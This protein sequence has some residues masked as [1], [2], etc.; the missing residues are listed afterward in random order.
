MT[1]K[2]T[3]LSDIAQAV[4]VSTAT[5]SRALNGEGYVRPELV[6]AIHDTARKLKYRS[7]Q[8]LTGQRVLLVTSEEAMLDSTRSQFSLYVLE[9]LRQRA[10]ILDAE[11]DV[12]TTK[13]DA[14]SALRSQSDKGNIAGALLLSVD[15]TLLPV[16]REMPCPVVI[17]NGDDPLMKLNSVTPCN[18]S[19]SALATQYLA[20]LGHKNI[21]FLAKPGRRTIERRIEGWRDIT[22]HGDLI[23]VSDWTVEAAEHALTPYRDKPLPF[24]AIVAAGDVLAIGA[25]RALQAMG[26]RVPED[27]S[28]IGIDGL[29]MGGLLT[30]ALTTM[31]IP[32]EDV[33]YLAIDMLCDLIR[34]RRMRTS[35]PVRRIEL[36]CN[37]NIRGTTGPAPHPVPLG[38]HRG[39]AS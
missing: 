23:H 11:L 27:V 37:L 38:Q 32:M 15:D 28:V 5:V 10:R 2:K 36:A 35:S 31:E 30:P 17:V 8:A 12:L 3:R 20:A 7:P 24:T 16:A 22:Q 39:P 9:G 18:R 4:G 13:T 34:D 25:V 29:P 19:A 6:E 21:A 26:K 1:Q 33:G 14:E